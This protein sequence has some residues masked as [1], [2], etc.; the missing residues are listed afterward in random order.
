MWIERAQHARGLLARGLVEVT[1]PRLA[2]PC[3][4][5]HLLMQAALQPYVDG[6]ISKTVV[7]PHARPPASVMEIFESAYER[8]LKGCTVFRE[9]TRRAVLADSL[10]G[11]PPPTESAQCYDIEREC[12]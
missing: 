12:D 3:P 6:A 5:D 7:L 9:G 1:V 11:T 2:L 10:G 4:R 8:K